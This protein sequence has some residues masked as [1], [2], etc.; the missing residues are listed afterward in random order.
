[1]YP[2][3]GGYENV[4]VQADQGERV[5]V[6]GALSALIHLVVG[7]RSLPILARGVLHDVGW[8]PDSAWACS[9][10]KLRRRC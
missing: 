7:A 2:G 8:V 3:I 6:A 1:M 10:G 4:G 5:D 9:A